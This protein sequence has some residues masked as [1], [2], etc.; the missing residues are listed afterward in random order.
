MKKAEAGNWIEK[1][2]GETIHHRVLDCGLTVKIAVKKGFGKKYA[3]LGTNYG[4]IDNDFSTSLSKKRQ[5][6]PAGIAH[7]L[8]HKMFE[9]EDGDVMDKLA[10]LGC[11]SNAMTSFNHTGYLIE[12]SERFNESLG[13]LVDFVTRPW[14]TPKLVDKEKGI[15][16]EEINMYRDDPSW[17]GY[18][19]VLESLYFNHPVAVDIAGTVESIQLITSDDLYLC[20]RTFYS[21]KNMQLAVAGDCDPNQ[22]CDLAEAIISKNIPDTVSFTRHQKRPRKVPKKRR[23][24]ENMSV[25][26]PKLHLG[27]QF[28][29]NSLGVT[30]GEVEMCFDLFLSSVLSKGTDFHSQLYR[31][32]LI[33]DSFG[34][35]A[36]VE[37]EFAFLM[38]AGDTPVPE[39]LEKAL[40]EGMARVL[41]EGPKPADLRRAKRKFYGSFIRGLDS[42]STSCWNLIDC[43]VKGAS[44][45]GHGKELMKMDAERIM[46]TVRAAVGS[47]KWAAH[48]IRPMGQ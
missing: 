39:K 34:F 47:A 23:M 5:R 7:F 1:G 10:A 37:R 4:S 9:K 11:S 17:R 2:V 30:L 42:V 16:A 12:C 35:S 28:D 15:I 19:G 43:H 18:M 40:M 26:G 33:D 45:L 32:N 48:I 29:P 13:I 31:A 36:S 38:L 46:K 41:K 14:F 25:V 3:L 6:L 27:C 22:V 20:H 8:E 21:P 44:Y 24:V